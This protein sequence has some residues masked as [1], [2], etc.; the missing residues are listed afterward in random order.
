[1]SDILGVLDQ[2]GIH[3]NAESDI[4]GVLGIHCNAE[5]DMLGVLGIHAVMQRVAYFIVDCLG[6]VAFAVDCNFRNR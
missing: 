6:L 5:S 1:M 2:L 4:L 3:C